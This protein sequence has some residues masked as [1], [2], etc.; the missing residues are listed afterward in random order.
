MYLLLM[1][2]SPSACVSH[3]SSHDRPT[4]SIAM[5]SKCSRAK[6]DANTSTIIAVGEILQNK[7]KYKNKMSAP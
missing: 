2:E 1:Q 4:F 6:T 7:M 5:P 3:I